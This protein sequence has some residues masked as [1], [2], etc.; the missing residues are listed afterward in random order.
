MY[1]KNYSE[2]SPPQREDR[3][4]RKQLIATRTCNVEFDNC[5]VELVQ[6]CEVHGLTRQEREYLKRHKFAK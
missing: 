2:F 6:G 3:A 1:P 4:A 5:I